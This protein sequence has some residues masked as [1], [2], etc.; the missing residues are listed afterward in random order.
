MDITI[1][2]SVYNEK[3]N[4]IPLVEAVDNEM[5]KYPYVSDWEYIL[6]DDASTDGSWQIMQKLADRSPQYV[7]LFRHQ[8]RRGQK[9]GFMTGFANA[10]GKWS[11]LMDADLQVLPSEL[12]LLLDKAVKE[13]YEM[14]CTYNDSER[15]GKRQSLVSRIGNLFMKAFFQS[16]VRDAGG[17]FMALQTRYIR[18]VNLVAND[19]RYLLPIC[20]GRGLKKIGEVGCV[21]GERVY[22]TSKYSKGKKMLQGV[23]EMWALKRRLN[24]GFYTLPPILQ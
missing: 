17:N 1:I 8:N 3:G 22:G 14:V 2:S 15:G 6:V 21:F 12:P 20:M 19:Q 23:P 24:A 11:I 18:G 7:R 4:L 13:G 10:R 5:E 16:P 9:G